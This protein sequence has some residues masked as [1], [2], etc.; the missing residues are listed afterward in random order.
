M[1]R[2]FGFRATMLVFILRFAAGTLAADSDQDGVEDDLDVCCDTP[3]G[4]AVDEDG[5][6]ISDFDDDCDGDLD[7]YL[8]LH[9]NLGLPNSGM[10][11]LGTFATFQA[12][13]TGAISALGAC[14]A[15]PLDPL[16]DGTE[17]PPGG[18]PN[19][20]IYEIKT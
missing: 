18:I 4:I 11:D 5:R 12:N 1:S 13:L 9:I 6:P 7:D 17:L 3:S 16:D 10:D 8:L 15:A 20:I 19:I 14:C 2:N